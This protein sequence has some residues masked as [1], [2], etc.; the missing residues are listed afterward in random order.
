MKFGLGHILATVSWVSTFALTWLIIAKVVD[1]RSVF[2]FL[3][4]FFCL[5]VA[6]SAILASDKD[7][8]KKEKGSN[9]RH[10]PS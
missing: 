7:D 6:T 1:G 5:A 3:I 10:R 8:K 9:G 4:F 2:G